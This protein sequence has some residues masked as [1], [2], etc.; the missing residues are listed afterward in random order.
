MI[1]VPVFSLILK[2][3]FVLKTVALTVYVFCLRF[4]ITVTVGSNPLN[5][6]GEIPLIHG[7]LQLW[8]MY[9]YYVSHSAAQCWLNNL[10]CVFIVYVY[11]ELTHVLPH[12]LPP[13]QTRALGFCVV[14]LEVV[15]PSQ[16]STEAQVQTLSETTQ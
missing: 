5:F 9:R 1:K 11:A 8:G 15:P 12:F 2:V 4:L 7:L 16:C 10:Q 3:F 6:S 14:I 13:L